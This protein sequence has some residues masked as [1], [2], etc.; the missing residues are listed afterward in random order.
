MVSK[1]P[2]QSQAASDKFNKQQEQTHGYG[3]DNAPGRTEPKAPGEAPVASDSGST[4]TGV[5]PGTNQRGEKG[6][7]DVPVGSE[8]VSGSGSM[9]Q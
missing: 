4:N 5:A 2:G 7:K 1:T 9:K 3:A 6:I 8:P